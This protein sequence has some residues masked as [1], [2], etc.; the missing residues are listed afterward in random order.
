MAGG[1]DLEVIVVSHGAEGL[2]RNCLRSL[3]E[4]PAAGAMG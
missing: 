2:L 4:H 3:R 1:L